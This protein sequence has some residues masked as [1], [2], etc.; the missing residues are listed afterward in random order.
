MFLYD[1]CSY[2]QNFDD[3]SIDPD[4]LS[5]SF[6]ARFA[7]PTSKI[8]EKNIEVMDD[9]DILETDHES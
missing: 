7:A 8:F 5:R 3:G 1:H 9:E 6:S 4:N 2:L